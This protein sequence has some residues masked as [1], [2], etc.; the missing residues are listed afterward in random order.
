VISGYDIQK[1]RDFVE[2]D[3]EVIRKDVQDISEKLE[4]LVARL[5][6]LEGEQ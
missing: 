6:E 1:V 2:Q 3:L 5:N 4:K